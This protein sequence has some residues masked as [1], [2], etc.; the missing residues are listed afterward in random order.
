M[1]VSSP[2]GNDSDYDDS[3][4]GGGGG[5]DDEGWWLGEPERN[6]GEYDGNGGDCGCRRDND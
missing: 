2:G 1:I 6:V 4:A 5:Q 3:C